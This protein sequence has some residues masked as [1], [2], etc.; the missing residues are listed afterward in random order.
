VVNPGSSPSN[1]LP[2]AIVVPPAEGQPVTLTSLSQTTATAGSP[3]FTL[4]VTGTGFVSG[5]LVQWNGDSLATTF[6]SAT[7]LT[8]FVPASEV[9]PLVPGGEQFAPLALGVAVVRVV[10][11]GPGGGGPRSNPLPVTILAGATQPPTFTGLSP[12]SAL[13]GAPGLTLTVTGTDFTSSSV[14][15]F[16]SA[17]RPTTFVSATQLRVT[18]PA[19]DLATSGSDDIR[20]FTAGAGVSNSLT[21]TVLGGAPTVTGL[22]PSSVPSGSPGFVLTVTGSGFVSGAVVRFG[23]TDLPTTFISATELH[24]TVAAASL[25][26][27]PAGQSAT[28]LVGVVNPGGAAAPTPLP[29]TVVGLQL[30]QPPMITGLSQTTVTSG[31]PELTLTITG[32]GFTPSSIVQLNDADRPTTFVS[33]TQLRV[34]LGAPDLVATGDLATDSIRVVNPGTGASA[35]VPLTIIAPPTP[36]QLV[37]ITQLSTA[38][39]TSGSPGFTLTITGTGFVPGAVVQWDGED[40]PTTFI[41]STQLQAQIPPSDLFT[42]VPLGSAT[43]R[44]VIP[45]QD[46][47]SNPVPVTIHAGTG[48]GQP[49]TI[50]GLSQT[51]ALVGSPDVTLIVMGTGFTPSSVVLFNGLPLPTTY[52]S[53][54]ELRT[55]IPASDLTG[56]ADFATIVLRVFTPGAGVS[57]PRLFTVVGSDVE[58]IQTGVVIPDPTGRPASV[59]VTIGSHI[60]ATLTSNTPGASPRLTVVSYRSNPT[61]LDPGAEAVFFDLRIEGARS[62]DLATVR[63]YYPTAFNDE[64]NILHLYYYAATTNPATEGGSTTIH[65][66][67]LPTLDSDGGPPTQVTTDNTDGTDSGGYFEIH[68]TGISTPRIVDLFLTVLTIAATPPVPTPV[69]NNPPLVIA[70]PPAP[71]NLVPS[72]V[73][74]T[75]TDSPAQTLA[76]ETRF[77]T[78]TPTF[79]F[80]AP[81]DSQGLASRTTLNAGLATGNVTVTTS[82]LSSTT[83]VGGGGDIRED[84]Y[85]LWLLRVGDD[86]WLRL[87]LLGPTA[88]PLES[89]GLGTS[90]RPD[91]KPPAP[92][93]EQSPRPERQ[94]EQDDPVSIEPAP[95]EFAP[96]G[97]EEVIWA[98]GP[99]TPVEQEEDA[100]VSP[101]GLAAALV[102][103]G[104]WQMGVSERKRRGERDR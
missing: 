93:P 94:P 3:G 98:V 64:E 25:P 43:V 9:R 20:V 79:S 66:R 63:F 104:Y 77:V 12:S 45:A 42:V 68:F 11:P 47:V 71:S 18:L 75:V 1:A 57:N 78:S 65:L 82:G 8:A 80:T 91:G 39:V 53:A 89:P 37:T 59:T 28:I 101:W 50:T 92:A 76:R 85:W 62:S 23:T 60:R 27:V 67:R 4:T 74:L 100:A 15:L 2:L 21:F 38:D 44:V 88:S 84:K 40:R 35:A 54:T 19:S 41:S 86:V 61:G 24:A 87:D 103:L 81:T 46:I 36:G 26:T 52:V 7:Q 51:S 72:L 48:L 17:A 32:T 31:T 13:V 83:G 95:I 56:I 102:G 34:T 29:F 55:V 14:V 58:S 90:Q 5:S 69:V 10:N 33:S 97:D 73:T 96:V 99:V 22:S 6:V 30:P 49:P 70:Q 16:N